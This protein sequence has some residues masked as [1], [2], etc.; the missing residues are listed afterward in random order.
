MYDDPTD[1]RNASGCLDPT[2]HQVT[3]AERARGRRNL[4]RCARV[5]NAVAYALGVDVLADYKL[6]D[7]E[8]GVS[9]R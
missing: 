3:K 8:T 9:W 1:R 6:R 7:R 5:M 4:K 2:Y